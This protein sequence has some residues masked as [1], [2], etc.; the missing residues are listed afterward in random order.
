MKEEYNAGM[1]G[2]VKFAFIIWFVWTVSESCESE[3]QEERNDG[4][5]AL[6]QN[7]VDGQQAAF[8]SGAV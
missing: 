4:I 2:I 6:I 1:E 8:H 7:R 3:K 5:S